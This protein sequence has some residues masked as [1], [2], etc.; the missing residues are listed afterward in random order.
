MKTENVERRGEV[1]KEGI[2]EKQKDRKKVPRKE[3]KAEGEKKGIESKERKKYQR[4]K[5]LLYLIGILLLVI[6]SFIS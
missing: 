6:H 1:S 4:G 5:Y 3:G 2:I